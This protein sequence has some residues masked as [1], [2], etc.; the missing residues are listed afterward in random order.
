MKQVKKSVLLW[1]TPA[2]MYEL[3]TAVERYPEFLPWCNKVEVLAREG[4]TVTA[5]LHLAYAGVRY[6][7]TTRN[8]NEADSQVHME[9]VD[10]PFSH[11]DGVWQFQPLNKPASANAATACKIAFNLNYAFS[12]GALEAVVSP[13]F[14][15]IAN[16]F[17]D[18][19]VQRAE[20]LYGA[21]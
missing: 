7:F 12:S 21:R 2:E 11:L 19:F 3:V 9:L 14:D 6:A 4:D 16:T 17:V 5:R 13:V 15:R 10:G 20:G 18:S 8:R 1:Y